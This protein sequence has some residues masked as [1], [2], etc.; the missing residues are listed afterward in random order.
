MELTCKQKRVHKVQLK[1]EH[2]VIICMQKKVKIKFNS[3]QN[4]RE[5]TFI[6]KRVKIKLNSIRSG[7]TG[8][9]F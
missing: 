4:T 9:G 1:A 7:L 8:S 3:I 6:Q 2:M 5:V